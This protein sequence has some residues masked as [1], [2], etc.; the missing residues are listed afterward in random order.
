MLRRLA[1]FAGGFSLET[2][3]A[4]CAGS[5]VE[6]E[7][8]LDL[9]SS[10]VNKSL[11]VAQTLEG[12][13]ARYH[14]LDVIRQY[15]Q[16]KL[17]NSDEWDTLH[18]H[19]LDFFLQLVEEIAPKLRGKYQQF[20]LNRLETEYDNIRVVLAWAQEQQYIELGLRIANS[21]SA[22][23]DTRGYIREGNSW[24][25]GLL[26]LVDDKIPLAVRSNALTHA[27]FLAMF[28][29]DATT[30][31]QHGR[32]AV[33]LCEAAGDEARPLLAFALAGLVSSARAAGDLQTA[34]T[35]T[36][37]MIE[38]NREFADMPM[39]GMNLFIQGGTAI[40]LGKYDAARVLL[41]ESLTIAR[42]AD[43][44][45]RIAHTHNSLGDL[46]RCEGHFAQAHAHYEECLTLL[47][48]LGAARDI[49]VTLHNQAHVYLQQGDIHRA[50]ALFRESLNAQRTRNNREGIIQGLLGFAAL[51]VAS[52]LITESAR[53]FGAAAASGAWNTAIFWPA[54]AIEQ[55]YYMRLI[56]AKLND[57]AFEAEQAR[58]R[59]LSIEQAIEYALNLPLPLPASSQESAE[60]G[61]ELTARER[62]VVGMIALGKSN[63]QIAGELVLSKRTVEKHIANILSKLDFSSRAQIVRWAIENEL[64]DIGH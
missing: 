37:R 39:L 53:L 35:I 57:T 59:A 44:S 30:A 20:W 54:K 23:W 60:P 47:R 3:E 8:V 10:L 58:G 21:L 22:F 31:T 46:A 12:S 52:G 61:P 36:E 50:H 43:D 56:Q 6:Q 38:L 64:V 25:E 15:A 28:L 9:L 41:E 29:G 11:V 63:G 55:D 19:Y 34:Y 26:S 4:V 7:Q 17:E 2:A 40:T 48:E 62:E 42:Q 14:L 16:E 33:A 13:V 49:P 18:D 1:I 27:S 32:E 51:A 45:Y 24:F 5:A